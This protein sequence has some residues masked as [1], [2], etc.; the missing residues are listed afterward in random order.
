MQTFETARLLIRPLSIEDR[1]FYCSCYTDPLLMQHIGEPLSHEA[2]SQSFKAALRITGKT[3]IRRYTWAMQEKTTRSNI[4]LL[5][6]VCDQVQPEPINAEIGSIVCLHFQNQGFAAEAISALVDVA[7]ANTSLSTLS[8]RHI[9]QNGA[10][11][12]LMEKLGFQY[13]VEQLASGASFKW[14]LHRT[15]W[16]KLQAR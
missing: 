16:Q 13:E 10:A 2:A 7:L 1:E 11:Y 9:S 6:L 3:P 12:G 15:E 14:Q 5:A 8:T 4:G